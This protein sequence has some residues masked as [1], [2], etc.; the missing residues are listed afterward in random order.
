MN[1]EDIHPLNGDDNHVWDPEDI[2]PLNGGD[3]WAWPAEV[4][5]NLVARATDRHHIVC[6]VVGATDAE[7]QVLAKAL[8]TRARRGG[9]PLTTFKFYSHNTVPDLAPVMDALVDTTPIVGEPAGAPGEKFTMDLFTG[10]L[11]RPVLHRFRNSNLGLMNIA[12]VGHENAPPVDRSCTVDLSLNI[13]AGDEVHMLLRSLLANVDFL[14]LD[15][16][17]STESTHL[18]AQRIQAG[19]IDRLFCPLYHPRLDGFAMT[20]ANTRL[21]LL[22][23]ATTNSYPFAV[24]DLD[25]A[26]E[27]DEEQPAHINWDAVREAMHR[28]WQTGQNAYALML[29]SHRA[30][31][32]P[33]PP[34]VWINLIMP[35]AML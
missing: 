20:E 11:S 24:V 2:H 15:A 23:D 22:A 27:A 32:G 26:D 1:P 14:T 4:I 17:I 18:L 31:V 34:E 10:R 30:Q 12:F 7:M 19:T 33:I 6:S 8:R 28:E 35:M 3:D 13:D 25:E 9:P 5:S 21:L 16:P 29:A